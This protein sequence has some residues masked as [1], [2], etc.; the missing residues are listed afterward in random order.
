MLEPCNSPRSNADR[1]PP[2]GFLPFS[3]VECCQARANAI[4]SDPRAWDR[5]PKSVLKTLALSI[6]QDN[7]IIEGM[8]KAFAYLRVSGKGQ[9]KGDGLPR[10]IEAVR[11]YAAANEIKIVR[12]FEEKGVSGTLDGM[13][14]PAWIEMMSCILANGIKT[15]LIERLDRLARDLMIQEH[16]IDDLQRDEVRLISVAEPDLCSNDPSRKLMRQIMG[17]I[18]E[19]DK[20]MIVAKLRAARRKKR[21]DTGRCEGRK[22]YGHYPGEA[23]AA[24]RIRELRKTETSLTAIAARMNAEGKFKPRNAT[25]YVEGFSPNQETKWFPMTISRILK[26]VPEI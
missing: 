11:R 14:R 24:A 3:G 19:Y 20:R 1:R 18:A 6:S 4:G 7:V 8:I 15:I 2:L 25:P 22:P 5:V 9:V 26:R 10:Q 16:I 13:D 23:E 21:E 17:A 12:V